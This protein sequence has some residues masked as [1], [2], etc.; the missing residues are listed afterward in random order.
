MPTNTPNLGLKVYNL[1]SDSSLNFSTL[2]NDITGSLSGNTVKISQWSQSIT[3]SIQNLAN[4][5]TGSLNTINNSINVLSASILNQASALA[6]LNL[7][8]SLLYDFVASGCQTI[9]FQ[10]PQTYNHLLILG[11]AKCG[12]G[13]SSLENTNVD[14]GLDF[15]GDASVQNY[16]SVQFQR[17]L[18]TFFTPYTRG[19][20]LVG[21]VAGNQYN[22]DNYTPIF[23][24]VPN[25]RSNTPK[26]GFGFNF[27]FTPSTYRVSIQGGTWRNNSPITR[28][29]MFGLGYG[30]QRIGFINNS[31]ISFYGLK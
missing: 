10:V 24:I 19:E 2:I 14:V 4:N 16:V 29:R 8:I 5:I 13:V 26:S 18:V 23:A 21:S 1:T 3:G 28:I 20:V 12:A 17:Q 27:F 7:D 22:T 11:M 25:Y 6:S 31:R 9:D 15:N 30:S